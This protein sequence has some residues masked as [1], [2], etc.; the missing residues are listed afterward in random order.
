MSYIGKREKVLKGIFE[1]LQETPLTAFRQKLPDEMIFEACAEAGYSFRRRRYGPA[2]TVFHFLLQAIQREESFAGTWAEIASN[3]AGQIGVKELGYNSSAIS[4]ARSRFPKAAFDLLVKKFFSVE[5]LS[6]D[7]WRGMRLLALDS[8]TV[9]MP[10]EDSLF[11]HFGRHKARGREVRYPLGTFCVLLAVGTSLILDYRFGPYDPG[12]VRSAA[13]LLDSVGEGDLVLAD[14]LFAGSP[15]LA[16]ILDRKADFLLRKN[17]RLAIKNLPVIERLGK[18]DFITEIPIGVPARRNDRALPAKVRVRLCKCTWKSPE[19]KRA[20]EW[21]VTS[22]MERRRFKPAA[23]A[24]CYHERWR[25]ETSFREFKVLFHADVLRS[26][27]VEN[28]Q[29]EFCAHVLAYQL[30]RL[31]IVEAAGKHHKKPGEISFLH[32]ARWVIAFSARMSV[33]PPSQLLEMYERLIDAIASTGV[34][35]RPGRIEPRV[36]MREKM[37]Y[38]RSKMSRLQWLQQR[39]KGVA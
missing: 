33:A 21:F 13:P 24:R 28:A 23:L 9:S 10:S 15:S 3:A 32:A 7:M 4:Q 22:L 27:T 30:L 29:K 37:H 18:N 34:T 19:G 25:I 17:A 1:V 35:S 16:R 26:K 11:S 8:T 36:I 31:L 38:P 39:L 12:E 6:F 2:C 20:K 5:G 14:R